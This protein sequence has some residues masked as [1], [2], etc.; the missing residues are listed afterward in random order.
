MLVSMG[1]CDTSKALVL[2][3]LTP[4]SLWHQKI[5]DST[6][7]LKWSRDRL[8]GRFSLRSA[9]NVNPSKV[10]RQSPLPLDTFKLNICYQA[11]HSPRPSCIVQQLATAV[12]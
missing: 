12:A 5:A 6:E 7:A 10:L 3:V 4:Q 11:L 2:G 1:G 9:A 8:R